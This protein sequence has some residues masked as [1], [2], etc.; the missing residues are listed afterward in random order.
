MSTERLTG[1][2]LLKIHRDQ[3]IDIANVVNIFATQ[4]HKKDETIHII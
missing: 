2:T 1:L 3:N 4:Q